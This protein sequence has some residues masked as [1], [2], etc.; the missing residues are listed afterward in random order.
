M[1]K[2]FEMAKTISKYSQEEAERRLDVIRNRF[3]DDN[4]MYKNF[5][6]VMEASMLLQ[7]IMDLAKK[8][9]K[10]HKAMDSEDGYI[11]P[12]KYDNQDFWLNKMVKGIGILVM[13]QSLQ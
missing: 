9:V 10:R 13:V 8:D 6:Y 12:P 11:L 1:K 3:T 7:R 2:I 4:T 5:D